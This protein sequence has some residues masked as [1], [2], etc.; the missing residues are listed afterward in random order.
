MTKTARSKL[1][2][3][4]SSVKNLLVTRWH[5]SSSHHHHWRSG[6][7][8]TCSHTAAWWLVGGTLRSH[9]MAVLCR[10]DTVPS[11][12][13]GPDHT[14]LNTETKSTRPK[15][16]VSATPYLASKFNKLNEDHL[17]SVTL[18]TRQGVCAPSWTSTHIVIPAHAHIHCTTWSNQTITG[19]QR[20]GAHR[21]NQSHLPQSEFIFL[22]LSKQV[23]W[24]WKGYLLAFS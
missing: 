6:W 9:S 24:G 15:V 3:Q 2:A 20:E 1:F 21:A 11:S 14:V 16:T 23:K 4:A 12:S 19:A 17:F 10:T 8:R 7:H 13:A 18:N 22:N 5:V